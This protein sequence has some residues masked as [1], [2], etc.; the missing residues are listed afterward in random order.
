MYR[1]VR[2]F[3]HQGQVGR[4]RGFQCSAIALFALAVAFLQSPHTWTST[5][6]D[7][8]VLEGN[9][10]YDV[11]LGSNAPYHLN[12]DDLTTLNGISMH[13]YGLTDPLQFELDIGQIYGVV[14][15]PTDIDSHSLSIEDALHSAFITS[16]NV[17]ATFDELS[18]AIVLQPGY[19]YAIVDSH[20][21]NL[22]GRIDPNGH[23][24]VL[25]FNTMGDL[26]AYLKATYMSLH[27]NMSP[28]MFTCYSNLEPHMQ[29]AHT[30]MHS[31]QCEDDISTI[32]ASDS[33]YECQPSDF[34]DFDE[35]SLVPSE[36]NLDPNMH[37]K[38]NNTHASTQCEDDISTIGASDSDCESNSVP[39]DQ[40]AILPDMTNN[41]DNSPID[42]DNS[43]YPIERSQPTHVISNPILNCDHT[44]ARR[45]LWESISIAE[46]ASGQYDQNEKRKMH[47]NVETSDANE[48]VFH[49]NSNVGPTA[50]VVS[51]QPG[52]ERLHPYDA[53]VRQIAEFSCA[54]CDRF[55]FRD[56]LYN[57]PGNSGRTLCCT[58]HTAFKQHRMSS[59]SIHNNLAPGVVP[60]AISQL[61]DIEK[62]FLSLIRTYIG[63]TLLKFGG[64]KG[65]RG[66]SVNFPVDPTESLPPNFADIPLLAIRYADREGTPTGKKRHIR[67]QKIVEA[68]TWLKANNPLYADISIPTSSDIIANMEASVQNC[69]AP[70][71]DDSMPEIDTNF[72][73]DIAN[74]DCNDLHTISKDDPLYQELDRL[75]DSILV[76]LG[77]NIP[78]YTVEQPTS[79]RVSIYNMPYGEEKAF[80][81]LLPYGVNGYTAERPVPLKMAMYFKTRA[82]H[83]SGTFRKHVPWLLQAA[84]EKDFHAMCS[85]INVHMKMQK[86]SGNP[87]DLVTAG[88]VVNMQE[89]PQLQQNSYMFMDHMPGTP[90]FFKTK[91][92]NLL[93]Q[94]KCFGPPQI[95]ATFTANDNW[96][97]LAA[98]LK[99]EPY[100]YVEKNKSYTNDIKS[101]PFM[102]GLHFERRIKAFLTH[103][104]YGEEQ[105]FGPVVDHFIRVEFQDRGAP[106][107]HCFFWL[108]KQ[109]VPDMT[110]AEG[111]IGMVKLIDKIIKTDLPDK[112]N[113]PE[114]YALVKK[115]QTHKHTPYCLRRGRCRFDFPQPPC[116]ETHL[117]AQERT[118]SRRRMFY[119]TKR[120]EEATMINAY[121]PILLRKW[122]GNMDVKMVSGV[123]GIA[124]YIC[125]YLCKAEPKALQQALATLVRDTLDK[126][127][128]MPLR[129]RMFAIGSCILRN[130]K[131]GSIEAAFKIGSFPLVM[132]SRKTV[133][134]NTRTPDQRYHVLKPLQE[135][136]QLPPDSTDIFKSNIIEKYHD[137]PDCLESCSLFHFA[138]WYDPC[139]KPKNVEKVLKLKSREMY[140]RKRTRANAVRTPRFSMTTDSHYYSLLL[141]TLPHR[142]ELS[143]IVPCVDAKSALKLKKDLLDDSL[144]TTAF[145]SCELEQALAHVRLGD[146]E[147]EANLPDQMDEC[148]DIMPDDNYDV[149]MNHVFPNCAGSTSYTASASDQQ[150]QDYLP[151][152]ETLIHAVESGCMSIDELETA[153]KNLTPDQKKIFREVV[154]CAQ[155]GEQ[156]HYFITGPG[157][158]GK[159]Y[160]IKVLQNYLTL[161]TSRV[162]GVANVLLGAPTGTASRNIHG[163]TLHSLFALPVDLFEQ[164]EFSPLSPKKL[165]EL[166]RAYANVQYLIIDEVSMVSAEMLTMIHQRLCQ[167][168]NNDQYFGG[169]SVI[170]LGDFFQLRPVHGMFAFKNT[171][172]WHLFRPFFLKSNLRQANDADF[173]QLC[174]RCRVGN[175]TTDDI[176]LLK[177][178]IGLEM[179]ENDSSCTRFYPT[180]ELVK[181]YNAQIQDKLPNTAYEI[182]A[183]HS[184]TGMVSAHNHI[185]DDSHIPEDDRDA[186][187]LMRSLSVSA[188]T[189]IMLI[190]N[191]DTS[192]GLINGAQGYIHSIETTLDA[193]TAINVI[194]DDCTV[195]LEYQNPAIDNSIR[196]QEVTQE[197]LYA[198]HSVARTQFPLIPSWAIT[199]HKGQGAS[200]DAACLN[201]GSSVFQHGMAYVALSRVRT[202]NRLYLEAF[203]PTSIHADPEVLLENERLRQLSN[204]N[205][206]KQ[207]NT[208]Q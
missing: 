65:C 142:N 15:M 135:R 123:T 18:I 38:H 138:A 64:L 9:A 139:P 115:Y 176:E 116:R 168:F 137:R 37:N 43:D 143:L 165:H 36:Q 47:S 103:I 21:R 202:F 159:S 131:M 136:S 194:F 190:R 70:G 91:L 196:I 98:L 83:K 63:I 76:P 104:I 148:E 200:V 105:P 108:D 118:S 155:Q 29:N 58:C 145:L 198:G 77:P 113:D 40:I 27:F 189:R 79:N 49:M 13:H 197:F 56:Q 206:D 84:T 157:G 42:S 205:H 59:I 158:C 85:S 156:F 122:K 195:G 208:K 7:S 68:F 119:A 207:K 30:H 48:H 50:H 55:L 26:I 45:T 87:N 78:E 33:D 151:G 4:N 172:L 152:D 12:H 89:N 154:K 31:T 161:K 2:G 14:G 66:L 41:N 121:N 132:S 178:R 192:S 35:N 39:F 107:V 124:Y 52:Y 169:L 69:T 80:P 96:P 174:N 71:I 114:L 125:A 32:G 11:V 51:K 44:Y 112:D 140:I 6:V 160:L 81:W 185:V 170:L 73:A 193:V 181:E 1:A 46:A 203:H 150:S 144:D 67:P 62:R 111:R 182:N 20:A 199:I 187:G 88:D 186:G 92:L 102:A 16:S 128:D 188:N 24:V 163:R 8:I 97:E 90:P 147:I 126:Q 75:E 82:M 25:N 100:D 149:D 184:Y 173:Q 180:L 93:A 153:I 130:R 191:I 175:P 109:H 53:T 177:S 95:F 134:I 101:D 99:N 120:S 201:L 54:E 133:T 146:L 106:H 61:N 22:Q 3:M 166:R 141:L 171:L 167:I 17:L 23:A 72:H 204:T 110:T 179:P 117:I 162:L 183:K 129:K 86:Q 19:G 60:P 34:D 74:L 28:V 94:I 164:M 10:L 57:E 127:P 5:D